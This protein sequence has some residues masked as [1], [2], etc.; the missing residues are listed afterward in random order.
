M[1]AFLQAGEFVTTH[2][3]KGEIKLYPW[4]D[5]ASFLLHLKKFY[6]SSDKSKPLNVVSMRVHKNMCLV[7]IDGITSIEQARKLV[8]K[9]LWID[10]E[11]IHLPKDRWFVQD[12]IGCQVVDDKTGQLYGTIV[13]VTHPGH[14]DVYDVEQPNG[15]IAYFPAVE[16]FLKDVDIT[17]QVVKVSPIEGMFATKENKKDAKK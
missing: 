3:I 4:S 6:L 15:Q 1:Q 13:N 16:E 8:G 5:D 10:R 14:H 12:L 2:G 7:T 9:V 17:N 11:D